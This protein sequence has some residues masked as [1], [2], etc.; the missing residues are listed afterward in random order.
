MVFVIKLLCITTLFY[1]LMCIIPLYLQGIKPACLSQV[2]DPQTREFIEKCL[3]PASERLSAKEL[4][5]HSFLQLENPMELICDPLQLSNLCPRPIRLP[6]S[7]PLSMDIDADNKPLSASTCAESSNGSSH[8]PVL[9]YQRA[10]KNNVF[11]L[12][13]IKNDDKCVSLTLRIADLCGKRICIWEH[14]TLTP[15]FR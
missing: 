9:E 10:H 5:Q 8:C 6:K 11:S 12:R 1:G 4:L 14:L 3:V 15:I 2:A 13:G 7:R